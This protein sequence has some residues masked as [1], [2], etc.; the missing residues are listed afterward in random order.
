MIKPF[1]T[2]TGISSSL[3]IALMIIAFSCGQTQVE[4]EKKQ[5]KDTRESLLEVNKNL[6]KTEEQKIEDFIQRYRWNMEETGSGH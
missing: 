2:R 3:F 4:Q 1:F 6:V 5:V